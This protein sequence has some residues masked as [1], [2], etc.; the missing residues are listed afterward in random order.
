MNRTRRITLGLAGIIALGVA[1]WF[2]MT[3]QHALAEAMTGHDKHPMNP[4]PQKGKMSLKMTHTHHIPALSLSIEKAILAVKAGE[5]AVAL[6]ELQKA[7]T[8]L[9]VVKQAVS[10]QIQPEIV[11][12]KC[13]IMGGTIDPDKVPDNLLREYKGQKVAFCCGGCPAS[14]DKLS[15]TEKEAKLDKVKIKTESQ[16][17]KHNH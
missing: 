17:P 14:W 13:P 4:S 2:S 11:N 16:S 3:P 15:D 6:S 5:D 10:Q 12:S 1:G 8:L 9:G 7:Q